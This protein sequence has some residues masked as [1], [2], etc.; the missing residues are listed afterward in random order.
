[1]HLY[2]SNPAAYSLT[3]IIIAVLVDIQC[4]RGPID[5]GFAK[6]IFSY[7]NVPCCMDLGI[8]SLVD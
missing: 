8:P 4:H 7:N 3:R 2:T 6:D 5:S 1:M